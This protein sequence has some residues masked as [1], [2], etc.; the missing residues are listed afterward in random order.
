M[1]IYRLCEVELQKNQICILETAIEQVDDI[2][3]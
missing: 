3:Q 2:H 1:C